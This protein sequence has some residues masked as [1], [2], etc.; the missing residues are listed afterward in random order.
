MYAKYQRF[1]A[2][3][4]GVTFVGNNNTFIGFSAGDATILNGSNN[5]VIG[6]V[7]ICLN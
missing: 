4:P 6:Y 3:E 7:Q 1:A 2:E 5:T